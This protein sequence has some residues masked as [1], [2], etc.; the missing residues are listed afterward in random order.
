MF[1]ERLMDIVRTTMKESYYT[2][3]LEKLVDDVHEE[4]MSV[5]NWELIIDEDT[6]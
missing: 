5:V 4:I 6:E 1:R 3:K 2:E